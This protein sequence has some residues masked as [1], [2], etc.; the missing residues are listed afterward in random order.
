MRRSGF[1]DVDQAQHLDRLGQRGGAAEPL[2]QDQ[3]FGDL[4]ADGQHRVERG[5]RLL[6]DHRD[7]VAADLAHLAPRSAPSRSRPSNRIA[8]PTMRPGGDAISRRIDSEVTLLPQPVSPT[9]ARVSP[10]RTGNDTPSTARTTPS[11]VKN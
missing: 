9:M 4:M 10:G 11:R 1:G 2:M 5:H 8:P 3:R 7:L 6:E